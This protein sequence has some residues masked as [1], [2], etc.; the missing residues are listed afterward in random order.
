MNVEFDG[1]IRYK[2]GPK[3]TNQTVTCAFRTNRFGVVQIAYD[4]KKINSFPSEP[5]M[6]SFTKPEREYMKLI[7]AIVHRLVFDA[8][9]GNFK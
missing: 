5:D 9:S 1:L 4:S 7:C 2:N 3:P 8:P 6:Y